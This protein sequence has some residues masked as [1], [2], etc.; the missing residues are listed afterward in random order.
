MTGLSFL[1][2][3][4]Y[5]SS[6]FSLFLW[7]RGVDGQMN[8][9]FLVSQMSFKYQR[10]A[11]RGSY[12]GGNCYD[13]CNFF[14]AAADS[15]SDSC[16]CGCPKV[17]HSMCVVGP[18]G[19]LIPLGGVPGTIISTSVENDVPCQVSSGQIPL[20]ILS[21]ASAPIASTPIPFTAFGVKQ[22]TAGLFAPKGSKNSK[23]KFPSTAAAAAAAVS[24]KPSSKKPWYLL[25]ADPETEVQFPT[26]E[27]ET[28]NMIEANILY[29]E[30][31]LSIE[32]IERMISASRFKFPKL[33]VELNGKLTEMANYIIKVR[34]KMSKKVISTEY[35]LANFPDTKAVAALQQSHT[36]VI[37][38]VFSSLPNDETEGKPES[39]LGKRDKD[40][41]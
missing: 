18:N 15:S 30:P 12:S 7:Y 19:Q 3:F 35:S 2:G 16:I 8:F 20:V 14:E 40:D 36:V 41:L 1:I 37:C 23:Q 31:I 6:G 33:S 24:S 21:E 9:T 5:L 4:P 11:C 10:G 25:I 39:I 38:P 22:E 17:R 13:E 34:S 28:L 29:E 27:I 32:N 26:E